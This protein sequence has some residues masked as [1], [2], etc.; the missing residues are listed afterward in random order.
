MERGLAR[1]EKKSHYPISIQSGWGV[2]VRQP[3]HDG[4]PD[5]DG[6]AKHGVLFN[7]GASCGNHM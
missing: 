4:V 5:A 6:G 2:R 7:D 3:L 1:L